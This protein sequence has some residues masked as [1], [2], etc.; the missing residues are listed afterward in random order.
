MTSTQQ[1][2]G[3]QNVVKQEMEEPLQDIDLETGKE[4]SQRST[5]GS[6]VPTEHSRK[7]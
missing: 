7:F 4:S 5:C 1:Q 3:E 2:R 6:N